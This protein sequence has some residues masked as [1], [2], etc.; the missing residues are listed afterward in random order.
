[1]IKNHLNTLP[2]IREKENQDEE[3]EDERTK[4]NPLITIK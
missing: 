3:S 2:K 4:L 1:M